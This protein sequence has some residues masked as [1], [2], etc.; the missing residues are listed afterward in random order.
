MKRNLTKTSSQKRRRNR[1]NNRGQK[2]PWNFVLL[3]FLATAVALY[4]ARVLNEDAAATKSLTLNGAEA[5]HIAT[6]PQMAETIVEYEGM[7]VSFNPRMHVP[8]WVCWELLGSEVGGDNQREN[9]FY[10]DERVEGCPTNDDYRGS[11]YDRGHMAPAADFHWSPTAMKQSFYFTN[12]CPQDH[13]LNRGLWSR[14]E[15]K[16]RDWAQADSAII[17]ITGPV[18]TDTI[19][20]TIGRTGV[21]VPKRFFK[22]IVSPYA[23]P[24]RGIAF[25]VP[26]GY[27]KGGMQAAAT[28]IDE[29]E[30]VT[31]H[32]F[33][34]QLPDSVQQIIESQCK[35]NFW[36]TL[37]P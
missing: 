33:L 24:P 8:N 14:I 5:E 19:D 2:W 35:F 12:I 29:V 15:G 7:T 26:N 37:K 1:A 17:V 32:D 10:S 34:D 16:C 31:G 30:R 11:G 25:L 4:G 20:E 18:L 13:N 27:L 9:K 6:N 28:T 22:V 3:L 23:N 21:A 36:S